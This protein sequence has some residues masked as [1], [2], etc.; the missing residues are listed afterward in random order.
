MRHSGGNRKD[1]NIN[2]SVVENM[3]L[4]MPPLDEQ[5][6]FTQHLNAQLAEADVIVQATRAQLAEIERLPQK[7]LAQAFNPQGDVA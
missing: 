7:L 1:P 2:K 4:P 5:H 6:Q 3:T